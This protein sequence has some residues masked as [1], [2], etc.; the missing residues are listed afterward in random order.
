MMADYDVQLCDD[1]RVGEFVVKFHGPKDSKLNSIP[2]SFVS[3]VKCIVLC[4][5]NSQIS[6]LTSYFAFCSV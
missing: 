4:I 6:V 2:F 1:D 5:V 3:C